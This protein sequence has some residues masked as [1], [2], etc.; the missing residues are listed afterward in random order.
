MY[1]LEGICELWDD[2]ARVRPFSLG[3]RYPYALTGGRRLFIARGERSEYELF[4]S[5]ALES[6]GAI[7][8]SAGIDWGEYHEPGGTSVNALRCSLTEHDENR[9]LMAHFAYE[10]CRVLTASPEISNRELLAAV[11]PFIALIQDRRLLSLHE[12]QGLF[13]ELLFLERLLQVCGNHNIP[14]DGAFEAWRARHRNSSRDFSRNGCVVEVKA[15]GRLVREHRISSLH[16]LERDAD[17]RALMLYSLSVAPDASSETRLC[18]L[19]NR[20]RR[21]LR[22]QA[23][24]FDAAL[25]NRG[26]DVR[27]QSAYR[28]ST[29]FSTTRFPAAMFD[30]EGG[31]PRLRPADFAE[32]RLPANVSE[33]SYTLNLH[34][35]QASG[36]PLSPP[37]I[38]A[39][40]VEMLR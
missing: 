31:L 22:H 8:L 11:S 30:V 2:P 23:A 13:G 32:G 18:D 15:T 27:F 35:F 17:E 16:Q 24:S 10:C 29:P 14:I 12:Q 36:N 7:P 34:M 4:I 3:L 9:R 37:R 6:F 33:L 28:L 20:V 5:G 21:Q 1:S 25:E 19:V 40:L 38:D 39:F 26:Y